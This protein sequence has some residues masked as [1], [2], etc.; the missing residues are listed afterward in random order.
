LAYTREWEIKP[1]DLNLFDFKFVEKKLVEYK[2]GIAN[3]I[4]DESLL[5]KKAQL[6]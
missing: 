3:L 6:Y 5:D 4:K 1:L 2:E